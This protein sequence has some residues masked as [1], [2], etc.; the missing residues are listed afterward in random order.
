MKNTNETQVTIPSTLVRE[1]IVITRVDCEFTETLKHEIQD[2][3]GRS[4]KAFEQIQ[5]SVREGKLF[6]VCP[7]AGDPELMDLFGEFCS[8][9]FATEIPEVLKPYEIILSG[10]GKAIHSRGSFCR[11]GY[12]YRKP[13][14][15]KWHKY[16]ATSGPRG[17]M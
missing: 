16:G 1:E 4:G 17:A 6:I 14:N 13:A 10:N 9:S 11:S 5:L 12:N 7:H 8:D 2:F 3:F 15:H